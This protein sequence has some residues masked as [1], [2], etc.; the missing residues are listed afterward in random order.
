MAEIDSACCS[1][2]VATAAAVALTKHCSIKQDA[3]QL[4][5]RTR[6]QPFKD[7]LLPILVAAS[8]S[9]STTN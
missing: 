7:L 3:K 5:T 2:I 1:G 6:R 8:L 4:T 9:W